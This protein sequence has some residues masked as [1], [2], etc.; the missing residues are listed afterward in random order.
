MVDKKNCVCYT[1]LYINTLMKRSSLSFVIKRVSGWCKGINRVSEYTFKW[2][3]ER[4]V[5]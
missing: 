2:L 4:L 3:P 1:F 5:G